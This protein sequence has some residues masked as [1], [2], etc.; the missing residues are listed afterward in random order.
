M[1]SSRLFLIT[2]GALTLGSG[3]RP[4]EPPVVAGP[5]TTAER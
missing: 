4:G 3:P 2:L 1:D 5:A